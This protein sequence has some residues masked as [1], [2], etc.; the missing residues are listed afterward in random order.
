MDFNKGVGAFYNQDVVRQGES[1]SANGNCSARGLAVI[2]AAWR[3]A[4]A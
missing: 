2:A 1:S 4:G 3:T